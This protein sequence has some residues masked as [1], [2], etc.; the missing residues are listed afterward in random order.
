MTRLAFCLEGHESGSVC[1]VPPGGG[2]PSFWPFH[3]YTNANAYPSV[4]LKVPKE[5]F[6]DLAVS[7]DGMGS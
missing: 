3:T 2:A 6:R 1:M 4:K 5:L 7:A